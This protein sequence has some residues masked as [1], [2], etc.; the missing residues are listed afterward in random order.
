MNSLNTIPIIWFDGPHRSGKGTQIDLLK[1][2]LVENW[3]QVFSA[4]G[5]GSREWLG[6]RPEDNKSERRQKNYLKLKD[7]DFPNYYERWREAWQRLQRELKVLQYKISKDPS[8][9]KPII[10]LDR[11]VL[12][13]YHVERQKNSNYDFDNLLSE[14][15]IPDIIFIISCDIVHLKNRFTYEELQTKQWQFR[16]NNLVTNAPLFEEITNN[17]PESIKGNTIIIN[18]LDSVDNVHKKIIQK[19][20]EK[21]L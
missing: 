12:S 3:R 13:R 9:K 20:E 6:E 1:V 14:A 15:I 2:F 10:L 19:V 21:F 17:L 7:K 5:H 18:A 8:V 11:T 16:R 4:K